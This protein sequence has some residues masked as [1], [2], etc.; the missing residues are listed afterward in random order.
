MHIWINNIF[1]DNF[2]KILCTW[3]YQTC[4]RMHAHI[5]QI[6]YT[7]WPQ[8][9]WPG[10]LYR[11]FWKL[12]LF[13]PLTFDTLYAWFAMRIICPRPHERA[14]SQI[15]ILL[16]F[17]QW[18]GTGWITLLF[19]I[20]II[21]SYFIY[22]LYVCFLLVFFWRRIK[23]NN[24]QKVVAENIILYYINTHETEPNWLCNNDKKIK[25]NAE[26]RHWFWNTEKM[27]FVITV[28]KCIYFCP[29]VMYKIVIILTNTLI[30][31]QQKSARGHIRN[32]IFYVEFDFFLLSYSN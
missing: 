5:V 23:K 3:P 8:V 31:I 10:N 21:S 26:E 6:L 13:I 2:D 12:S 18:E 27:F 1:R 22:I 15:C 29:F 25:T 11:T 28:E 14:K 30:N 7:N 17:S 16:I 32:L 20:Y 9:K 24:D 19:Y 4:A